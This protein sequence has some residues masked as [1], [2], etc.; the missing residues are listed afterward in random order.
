MVSPSK[1][2]QELRYSNSEICVQAGPW[3]SSIPVV[4]TPGWGSPEAG[5]STHK[6]FGASTQVSEGRIFIGWV[7][8]SVAWAEEDA[9]ADLGLFS[10]SRV[11]W[12]YG[13]REHRNTTGPPVPVMGRVPEFKGRSPDAQDQSA[14]PSEGG[15]RGHALGSKDHFLSSLPPPNLRTSEL[16]TAKLVVLPRPQGTQEEHDHAST[17]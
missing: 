2:A 6:Y 13:Q 10:P 15:V 8:T 4:P 14:W 16:G 5:N 3:E 1:Q 11:S 7:H 17:L 12:C 9:L